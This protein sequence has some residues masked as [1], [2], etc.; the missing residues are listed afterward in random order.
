MQKVSQA[1]RNIKCIG[2]NK[3]SD[4]SFDLIQDSGI[5][6]TFRGYNYIIVDG[7]IEKAEST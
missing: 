3:S 2:R 4:E 7:S 1:G 5:N 6:N